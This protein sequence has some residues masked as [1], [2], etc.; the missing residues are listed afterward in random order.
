M[1]ATER[2]CCDGRCNQGRVCPGN[3]ND[4]PNGREVRP[5]AGTGVVLAVMFTTVCIVLGFVAADLWDMVR[6]HWS[7][8]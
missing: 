3:E 6:A 2:F 4:D 1:N 5:P 8:R 7:V